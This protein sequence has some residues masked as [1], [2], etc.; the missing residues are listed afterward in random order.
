MESKHFNLKQFANWLNS[1]LAFQVLYWTKPTSLRTII[2]GSSSN[3]YISFFKKINKNRSQFSDF[4]F[5]KHELSQLFC[6]SLY[7][8]MQH[9]CLFS[10]ARERKV[11][12]IHFL[13][14]FNNVT[15]W[16]KKKNCLKTNGLTSTHL[17]RCV[18]FRSGVSS[19]QI[20]GVDKEI[21]SAT[22][23]ADGGC[24]KGLAKHIKGGN[25]AFD[26]APD[27]R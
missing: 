11:F 3:E 12:C 1:F 23:T 19:L 4:Q 13:V 8:H 20:G 26:D 27:F 22:A 9:L 14:W 25:S 21:Q 15:T 10:Q 16:V 7:N 5:S 17:F 24:S 2:Y 6:F 18:E